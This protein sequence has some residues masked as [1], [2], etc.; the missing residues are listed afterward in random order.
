MICHEDVFVA[1]EAYLQ[2]LKF[3]PHC[4]T[5]RRCTFKDLILKILGQKNLKDVEINAV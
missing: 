2:Q 5:L 3:Q 1:Q 4:N